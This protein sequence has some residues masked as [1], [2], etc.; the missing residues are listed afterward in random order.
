VSSTGHTPADGRPLERPMSAD[1]RRTRC[2]FVC[3]V[4]SVVSPARAE[5]PPSGGEPADRHA[6]LESLAADGSVSAVRRMIQ[7]ASGGDRAT[8]SEVARA[9]VPLGDRAVAGLIEARRADTITR[10]WAEHLLDALGKRTPGEMVQTNDEGTLPDVLLAFGRTGDLDAVA[11]VLSFVCS[12][13]VA[14]RVAARES[15]SAYGRDA[16]RALRETYAA[17]TGQP[18]PEGASPGDLARALFES[19]DRERLADVYALLDRGIAAAREGRVDESVPDLDQAIARAPLLDRR[20]EAAPAYIAYAESRPPTDAET[21]TEYLRKALRLAP[22]GPN[23]LLARS[24]LES[25]RGEDSFAHGNDDV[26]AFEIAMTLNPLNERARQNTMRARAT[27]ELRRRRGQRVVAGLVLL[28][29]GLLLAAIGWA[30]AGRPT[31]SLRPRTAP[32]P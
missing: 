32:P 2:L 27:T 16:S 7:L 1:A 14:I 20:A 11:T 10:A 21:A 30:G 28:A 22:D 31:R 5:A 8:Y 12:T 29:L 25:L 19:C 17:R 18:P 4:L 6:L 26:G 3:A 24:D 13:K 9:V 15:V 23:A